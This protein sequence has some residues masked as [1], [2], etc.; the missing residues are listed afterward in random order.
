MS[1]YAS[2]NISFEYLKMRWREPYVSGG[3]NKKDFSVKR[4]GIYSGFVIGVNGINPRGL[5]IGPGFVS[6]GVGTNV[7]SGYAQAGYDS[8]VGY[9]VAVQEV[10]GHAVTIQIPPS[11]DSVHTL[12]TTSTPQGRKFVVIKA[13]YALQQE[14]TLDFLLVDG[15]DLDLNPTWTVIGYVDIPAPSIPLDVSMLGY[16]DPIYPRFTPLSNPS[17]AGLMPAIAWNN[18]SGVFQYQNLLQANVSDIN[19][20]Y[21]TITPSQSLIGGKRIYSYA[22][23]AQASKF[24][25]N[26]QGKYNG[27]THNDQLTYLNIATGQISG[28][29]QIPGNLNFPRPGIVG[30]ASKYQIGL[31]TLS[32]ADNLFVTYSN[33]LA[34]RNDALDEDNMPIVAD[35][36]L[37]VAAFIASTDS[38]GNLI[39]L[40]P[41]N[42][43]IWRLPFLN[44]GQ[45]G[46]VL[47]LTEFYQE[48]IP[49]NYNNSNTDFFLSQKSKSDNCLLLF[50]DNAVQFKTEYSLM[51]QHISMDDAPNFGQKLYG[52]YVTSN[53]NDFDAYQ[54]IP[55]GNVDGTNREFALSKIPQDITGM[56]LFIQRKLVSNFKLIKGI[57][58]ASILIDAGFQPTLTQD[59]Y[60]FY[61]TDN[62][63]SFTGAQEV[64]IG[65][66]DGTND[67]FLLAKIPLD[68]MSTIVWVNGC[69]VNNDQWFLVQNY[70]QSYIQFVPGS[71]PGLGD[72]LWVSYPVQIRAIEVLPTQG[73]AT[74]GGLSV[75]GSSSA[76]IA[77]NPSIGVSV[78]SDVRQYKY[79]VST[80]G[81]VSIVANPQIQAGSFDGQELWLKGCSNSDYPIFSDGAGLSLNGPLLLKMNEA[82]ILVWDAQGAVWQEISR[83]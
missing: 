46:N 3:L 32:E 8:S 68:N 40:D 33:P 16:E 72:D 44:I 15:A 30:Q 80:G 73:G 78:N 49:G 52:F 43:L 9:S 12:D 5:D 2:K 48:V 26:P 65:L 7:V 61:V 62:A 55:V 31:I 42:D 38:G 11:S 56:F 23:T 70:Q 10:D 58:S 17:K 24:P 66:V 50:L 74:A 14:S 19:G 81:A 37:Q 57:N 6:G 82:V 45:G 76:P 53:N 35:N 34:S 77:I 83:R 21:V 22:K 67:T 1:T 27:G 36:F 29:H 64:P 69:P 25:R 79:I 60:V 41:G 47:D 63:N 51:S 54:E 71:V 20:F 18:L 13:T 59:I 75:Q 39:T 28:A 4:P